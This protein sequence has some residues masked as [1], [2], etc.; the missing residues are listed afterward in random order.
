MNTI[1]PQVKIYM[2]RAKK[3]DDKRKAKEE[4]QRRAEKIEN[5]KQWKPFIESVKSVFPKCLWP[6]IAP[7]SYGWPEDLAD[8]PR[9]ESNEFNWVW[10]VVPGMTPITVLLPGNEPQYNI[11]RVFSGVLVVEED[12][13][14]THKLSEALTLAAQEFK[15]LEVYNG[16]PV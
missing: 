11:C 1:P 9:F 8:C 13:Y 10:L 15:K 6:Y 2:T 4:L 3:E 14:Q 16:R 12:H 7:D 5:A